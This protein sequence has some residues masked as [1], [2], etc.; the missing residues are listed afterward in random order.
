MRSEELR[1][2]DQTRQEAAASE[3]V[4]R[5]RPSTCRSQL[6]TSASAVSFE[7]SYYS[8]TTSF[9]FAKWLGMNLLYFKAIFLPTRKKSPFKKIIP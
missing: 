6:Q 3:P 9:T 1:S 2:Q 5:A 4:S 8:I 7:Y